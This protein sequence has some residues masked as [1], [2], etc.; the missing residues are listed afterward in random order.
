MMMLRSDGLMEVCVSSALFG[1]V[2][3]EARFPVMLRGSGP[4]ESVHVG[5]DSVE[6]FHLK[7]VFKLFLVAT[8]PR[9]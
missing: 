2:V 4:E 8:P 9:L 3:C 7:Q 6:Y 5:V 1:S